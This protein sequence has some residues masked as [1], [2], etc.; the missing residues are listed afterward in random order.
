MDR[1]YRENQGNSVIT[2]RTPLDMLAYTMAEAIGEKV[3]TA[4]QQRFKNYTNDCFNVTNRWFSAIIVVQ[5]GI[6]L[7]PEEGKAALNDAYIEH[8][9]SLIIG[10][11]CDERLKVPH[12]YIPRWRTT[13]ED[14]ISSVDFATKHCLELAM[15]EASRQPS[16]AFH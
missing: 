5:P 14:R 16:R 2:D 4:D 1:F 6:T 12:F 10:L 8:L 3:S 9:N 15:T 13:L 7:V 11:C